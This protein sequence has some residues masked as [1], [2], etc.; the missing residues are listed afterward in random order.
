VQMMIES[1]TQTV[2]LAIER[3]ETEAQR[4]ALFVRE[5]EAREQAEAANRMKDEF[6]AVV[7]HELRT[8]LNAINGWVYMLLSGTLDDAAQLRALQSIQRQ[9]RSQC[10]LIDDL[11][12]VARIVS[13]KLRLELR[14]VDPARVIHAALDVVRPAA[15]AKQIDLVADLDAS[16]NAVSADSERLQQVIWNLLSNAI[17]FT[18]EGGC[19]EI[20]SRRFDSGIEIVVTDTGQGISPDFLPYVFDRFQQADV[21]TTRTHGGIGLGLAIVRHLVELHGGTVFATSAGKGKGATFTIRLPVRAVRSSRPKIA[22]GRQEREGTH[23]LTV[24]ERDVLEGVRVLVV[25][26]NSEDREV[27]FAELAHHGATVS[28]SSCVADALN[29][30]NQ[31]RPD[32]LVADIGMPG[33]DGYSLIRKVRRCPH[34]HGGLTP[35]IALTAYAGDSNRKR[36]LEAGYQKHMTKPAD[37]SE[38]TRTIVLLARPGRLMASFEG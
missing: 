23:D 24:E 34:D 29:E 26:D 20:R 12:D 3:K 21:S 8:P 5:Q 33:E 6:L 17:K 14:E 28:A 25:E 2:A 37:P 19:V 13:G 15:D 7:S 32:V 38:L 9:V 27:L 4:E 16:I 35:A 10:Q 22:A 1:V 36:A 18:P 11:L 30:L 31:F